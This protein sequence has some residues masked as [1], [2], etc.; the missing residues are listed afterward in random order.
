MSSVILT[1]HWA[2]ESLAE[3]FKNSDAWTSPS[4]LTQNL[5]AMGCT[6][7]YFKLPSDDSEAD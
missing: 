3:V 7:Q 6:R 4:Q 5:R 2:L 1:S